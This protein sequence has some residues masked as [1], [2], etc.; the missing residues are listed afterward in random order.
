MADALLDSDVVVWHLRGNAAVVELVLA[1]ARR[2]R[3]GL[4]AVTRAEVLLGMREPERK[5]TLLFLDSCETL[6][7]TAATAD[8][9]GEIFREFRSQGITLA[10]PDLLIGATALLSSIPLYTCNPRHYPMPDLGLRA[11]PRP[12]V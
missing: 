9:A 5:L 1:L 11:V 10:L 3:I 12:I 8:R 7:V 4:S 6:P 2:G